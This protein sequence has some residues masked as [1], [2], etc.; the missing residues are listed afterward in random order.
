MGRGGRGRGYGGDAGAE[1]E[2]DIARRQ[3]IM[4][5]VRSSS[6]SPKQLTIV[7]HEDSVTITDVDGRVQVLQTDDKRIESRAE[8]GLIKVSTR[9][10]WDGNTLISEVE[11]DNGPTIVRNY[12]LSPGGTELRLTTNVNGQGPA[13]NLLRF[14]ERPVESR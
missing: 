1:R 11:V 10:H 2:D 4:S 8:N 13:V 7:V 9:N 12:A 5:Y 3:A 14:Y 6:E